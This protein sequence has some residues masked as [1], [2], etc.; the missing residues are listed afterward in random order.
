MDCV[1]FLKRLHIL[2]VFVIETIEEPTSRCS[3]V[4]CF[5]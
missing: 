1:H 3:E 5:G 2:S 4:E